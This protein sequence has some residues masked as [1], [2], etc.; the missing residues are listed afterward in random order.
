MTPKM[1]RTY[2]LYFILFKQFHTLRL[3]KN[4]KLGSGN[5]AKLSGAC[6]A[7]EFSCIESRVITHNLCDVRSPPCFNIFAY[8]CSA[9][10]VLL[11]KLPWYDNIRSTLN[12]PRPC[13]LLQV[14]SYLLGYST[15]Y[16][17]TSPASISCRMKSSPSS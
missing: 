15:C 7:E 4:M 11:P 6:S 1:T 16:C 3:T 12:R 5:T 8:A 13:H 14:C 17:Q 9:L 10:D 2:H